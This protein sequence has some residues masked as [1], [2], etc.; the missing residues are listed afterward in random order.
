MQLA[1]FN[2]LQL[3]DAVAALRPCLDV[4]RWLRQIAEARPFPSLPALMDFA[5]TAANPFTSAEIQQALGHHPRIGER[6]TAETA[7]ASMSRSEQ[8]G[9]DPAD[10]QIARELAE[11]NHEYEEKFGHVFLIRAA[12]RS[13]PEIL[14]ALRER[15][16]HTP[17]QEEAIIA[18]QLREIA[19]LRLEGVISK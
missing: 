4:E 18:Q 8:A 1:V 12:G 14:A 6:P 17:D 10:A 11:G 16:T 13:A 2:A 5:R 9:V 3:G 19:L 15:L 7:E